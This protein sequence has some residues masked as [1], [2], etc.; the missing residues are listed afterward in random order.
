MDRKGKNA[1]AIGIGPVHW[2]W[3]I[4]DGGQ[5]RQVAAVFIL[6]IAKAAKA[7]TGRLAAG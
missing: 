6:E 1:D 7:A 2:G 3:T 4:V 5:H